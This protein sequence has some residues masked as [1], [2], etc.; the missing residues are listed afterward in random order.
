MIDMLDDDFTLTT[1]RKT[2]GKCVVVRVTL[3]HDPAHQS[4]SL[5]T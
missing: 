3:D 2:Y 4:A 5:P 1:K